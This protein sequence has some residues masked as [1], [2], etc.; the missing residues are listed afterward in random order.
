MNCII[1]VGQSQRQAYNTFREA[2]PNR[3]QWNQPNVVY[4]VGA[5]HWNPFIREWV[6]MAWKDPVFVVPA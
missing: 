6:L 2:E 4:G 1:Y 3:D 5:W